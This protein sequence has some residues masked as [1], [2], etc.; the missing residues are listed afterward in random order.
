M[1]QLRTELRLVHDIR[2]CPNRSQFLGRTQGRFTGETTPPIGRR[3]I[4]RCPVMTGRAFEAGLGTPCGTQAIT[5]RGIGP[6]APPGHVSH[7]RPL[8]RSRSLQI[9]KRVDFQVCTVH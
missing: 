7:L 2:S 6:R 1:A 5:V 4:L 9:R 3:L 8:P